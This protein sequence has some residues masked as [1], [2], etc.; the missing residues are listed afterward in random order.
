MDLFSGSDESS[1]LSKLIVITINNFTLPTSH[2][3]QLSRHVTNDL[4][5]PIQ[6]ENKHKSVQCEM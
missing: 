3:P 6:S 5:S 2:F 1:K 4:L